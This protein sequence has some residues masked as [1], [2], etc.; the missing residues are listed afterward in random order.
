MGMPRVSKAKSTT[1]PKSP[2]RLVKQRSATKPVEITVEEIAAEA[3]ALFLAR[4]GQHGD[5]LNDWLTAERIVTE[6]RT[7]GGDSASL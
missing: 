5:A 2:R 4:G 3:Y 6:R 1:E 7:N